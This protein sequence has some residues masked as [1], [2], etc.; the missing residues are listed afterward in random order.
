[1][2]SREQ[3]KYDMPAAHLRAEQNQNQKL[4]KTALRAEDGRKLSTF[5]TEW[6]EAEV[7]L[8]TRRQKLQPRIGRFIGVD[9]VLWYSST[10]GRCDTTR[11]GR[12]KIEALSAPSWYET[13]S[14]TPVKYDKTMSKYPEP[15]AR[16]YLL[17]PHCS[18]IEPEGEAFGAPAHQNRG[19][20]GAHCGQLRRGLWA[21][22]LQQCISP[23]MTLLGL[24]ASRVAFNYRLP[25][26]KMRSTSTPPTLGDC[27]ALACRV[28]REPEQV[29]LPMQCAS[30]SQACQSPRTRG[31]HTTRCV[32]IAKNWEGVCII[33][34]GIGTGG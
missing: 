21:I 33:V 11:Q 30:R 24:K 19:W 2:P 5:I 7:I 4:C 28:L 27:A 10:A 12:R 26:A 8:L 20:R 17:N 34:C 31:Y 18:P 14:G 1:M 32:W 9:G 25:D 29:P 16:E 22:V 15:P 3:P 23:A 13:S 6:R